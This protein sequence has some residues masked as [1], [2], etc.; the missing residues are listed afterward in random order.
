MPVLQSLFPTTTD[1]LKKKKLWTINDCTL[2]YHYFPLWPPISV[3]PEIVCLSPLKFYY[4]VFS[5]IFFSCIPSDTSSLIPHPNSSTVSSI[6]ILIR[7]L[8]LARISI[9]VI[10]SCTIQFLKHHNFWQWICGNENGLA[11]NG[12]KPELQS[13]KKYHYTVQYLIAFCLFVY[14]KS[15]ARP[16]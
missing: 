1:K 11:V 12:V 3:F 16:I 15:Q 7:I 9:H 4:Q 13:I 10:L 8:S 6:Q 2:W 14:H 5:F